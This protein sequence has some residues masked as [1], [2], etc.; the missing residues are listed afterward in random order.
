MNLIIGRP[1]IKFDSQ[2]SQFIIEIFRQNYSNQH[3]LELFNQRFPTH[4]VS[5]P[6]LKR[7]YESIISSNNKQNI[8]S[9]LVLLN[10]IAKL[11]N[12]YLYL[13]EKTHKITKS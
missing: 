4:R 3:I 2:Q 7:H 11:T 1:K 12:F 13:T 9:Y 6:V 8:L 10:E 5:Y